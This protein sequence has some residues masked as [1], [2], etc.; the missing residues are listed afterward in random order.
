MNLPTFKYH[1]N[2]IET[3]SIESSSEVCEC[4]NIARGYIATGIIYAKNDI[5]NICPW[6]ISDGSAAKKFNGTFV[7]DYPLENAGID[8]SIISE[9][10]E[11]TPGYNSWQQEIWQHCCNDACEYHGNASKEELSNL[12]SSELKDFLFKEMIDEDEWE[13][14]IIKNYQA[15]G[16]PGIYKFKCRHCVKYVYYM[17]YL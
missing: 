16:N 17:D 3:G 12:K 2:P 4:C 10:C 8:N 14:D 9:V 15:G 13:E 1:P 7:D 5:D 11:R 6:C